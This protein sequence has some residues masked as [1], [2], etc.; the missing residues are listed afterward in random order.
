MRK[1][2]SQSKLKKKKDISPSNHREKPKFNQKY[3]F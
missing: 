2:G 3:F 1:H